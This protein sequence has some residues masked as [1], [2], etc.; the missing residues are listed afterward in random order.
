MNRIIALV[1]VAFAASSTVFVVDPRHVVVLSGRDGGAPSV[2]GPGVHL[3]LPPPL[4]TG[5]S[6][7]VR[8]QTLE[9]ADPQS[10]TTADK[11]D[12]LVT[13]TVKYRVADP[14]A[15]Y[16]KSDNGRR[17]AADS[18]MSSL[19]SV[20]ATAI[21]TR[22][23]ADAIGAQQAIADDAKRA[24]TEQ[25]KAYGI[26]IV[27]VSLTRIDLPAAQ[28][29]VVYRQ[30]AAAQHQQAEAER[31]QGAADVQAIKAD[32]A[33]EQEQILADGYQRAQSI[34]G[35]GDA[36]AAAIAGEAFGRDPQFYQ[37]YA[38]LQAYRKTF[39][40]NDVI[41]VDPDSEFFRFMRSPTGGAAASA[42]AP[43]SR[44]H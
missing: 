27:G 3:K 22:T 35:E 28:A 38:S 20:L 34:K 40:E 36:K 26:E 24:L 5:T 19:K 17:D 12:V 32:A 31:A 15:Y 42:P 7:D 16:A 10:C 1:I 21:S 37:F 6:I 41:V 30:M 18:L 25:A 39:H 29:D 43:A 9:W 23:L 8:I 13:P 33:R 11:L 4:Q 2:V 44:K 14:L